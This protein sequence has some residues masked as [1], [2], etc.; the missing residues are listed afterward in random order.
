MPP[1]PYQKSGARYGTSEPGLLLFAALV[2]VAIMDFD[3]VGGDWVLGVAVAAALLLALSLS[4]TQGFARVAIG[5]LLASYLLGYLSRVFILRFSPD[6]YYYPRE[7]FSQSAFEAASQSSISY[8]MAALAIL[9]SGAVT[10]RRR[11]ATRRAPTIPQ[12]LEGAKILMTISL[13]MVMFFLGQTFLGVGI[14]GFAVRMLP[15]DLFALAILP[16]SGRV[17]M[18]LWALVGFLALSAIS[19]RR[20][21]LV[22]VFLGVL[23]A[24]LL[25]RPMSS[26]PRSL[27]WPLKAGLASIAIIVPI[28]FILNVTVTQK[29][30]VTQNS[31]FAAY[32]YTPEG[33]KN[34]VLDGVSRLAAL[35]Q[36][37]LVFGPERSESKFSNL[38]T[39]VETTVGGLLPGI[40]GGTP[41]MGRVMAVEFQGFSFDDAHSG[42]WTGPGLAVRYFP[43]GAAAGFLVSTFGVLIY[44]FIRRRFSSE[45]EQALILFLG[46]KLFWQLPLSGNF[47]IVF[48]E[49]I[50]QIVCLYF[51]TYL[52]SRRRQTGLN[53][54]AARTD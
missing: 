39:A 49:V 36:T 27:D 11:S 48:S 14:L 41:S 4:R 50:A 1:A 40:G 30:V 23:S 19:G 51:I 44:N 21:A 52:L 5:L 47:D 7:P 37:I 10:P 6:Q 35:D 46:Y 22:L 53:A 34:V 24:R 8:Y 13:M 12:G 31:Q 54:P 45:S 38:R 2:T 9:L 16:L 33:V 18:R 26:R 42:G 28:M 17:D 43:S 20:Y 29:S 3:V 32:S 25:R 15:T